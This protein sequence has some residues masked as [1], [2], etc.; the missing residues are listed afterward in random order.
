MWN[1]TRPDFRPHHVDAA[2]RPEERADSVKVRRLK[3]IDK[4]REVLSPLVVF[5]VRGPVSATGGDDP[6]T[7]S[8]AQD[9]LC[10]YTDS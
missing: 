2:L 8:F 9:T 1:Q 7:R 3:E 5:Q 10:A 4:H 6:E